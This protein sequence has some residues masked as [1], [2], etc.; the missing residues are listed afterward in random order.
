MKEIEKCIEI[1]ET[2]KLQRYFMNKKKFIK[3][4]TTF[5]CFIINYFT[6]LKWIIYNNTK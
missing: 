3:N 6:P 4:V 2:T 5:L 1:Y